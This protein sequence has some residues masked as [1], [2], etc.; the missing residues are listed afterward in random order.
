MAYVHCMPARV[1]E[2][3]HGLDNVVQG[4]LRTPGGD[5][6]FRTRGHIVKATNKIYRSCP[7]KPAAGEHVLV[8]GDVSKD[9]VL[10]DHIER[11]LHAEAADGAANPHLDAIAA[12]VPTHPPASKTLR[13][14]RTCEPVRIR[15]VETASRRDARGRIQDEVVHASLADGH[16]TIW[17]VA[18]DGGRLASSGIDA[19]VLPIIARAAG[20]GLIG[21]ETVRE[22]ADRIERNEVEEARRLRERAAAVEAPP[23]DDCP[24]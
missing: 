4:V 16:W 9:A 13:V 1:I 22:Q 2:L 11:D 12:L 6:A 3:R 17:T 5:L 10:V 23:F 21:G 18:R 19:A 20:M 8:D 7:W 14:H 15:F 24:F